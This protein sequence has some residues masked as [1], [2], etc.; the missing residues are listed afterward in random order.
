MIELNAVE[1]MFLH[2]NMNK[3][4]GEEFHQSRIVS[5]LIFL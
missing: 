2:V 5:V 1:Q 4:E 3:L